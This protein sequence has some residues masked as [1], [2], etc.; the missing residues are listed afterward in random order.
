MAQ[1]H[2]APGVREAARAMVVASGVPQFHAPI[3]RAAAVATVVP[4]AQTE[5]G[6]VNPKR[7]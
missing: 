7:S 4:Y 2:A 3:V 5:P 6:T 1:V